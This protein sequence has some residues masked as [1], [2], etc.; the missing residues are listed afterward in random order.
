MDQQTY[1]NNVL[2]NEEFLSL[3]KAKLSIVVTGSSAGIGNDTFS[4][5]DFKIFVDNYGFHQFEETFGGKFALED[6]D[7]EPPCFVLVRPISFLNQEFLENQPIAL[8]IYQNS[9]VLRDDNNQLRDFLGYQQETFD[10]ALEKLIHSKYL[11]LRCRRHALDNSIKR[12]DDLTVE[13]LKAD[14]VIH[15]FELL[16]LINGKPFPYPKW[17]LLSAKYNFIETHEELLLIAGS[18]ISSSADSQIIQASRNYV[19]IIIGLMVDKG[20]DADLLKSWWFNI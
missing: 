3:R 7:H 2:D 11:R 4:D 1:I 17:L 6:N 8:W 16:H 9:K 19:D 12:G 5:W 10:T 13:L 20:Y 15:G 14:V 18:L